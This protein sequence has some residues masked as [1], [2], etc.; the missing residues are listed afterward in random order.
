MEK[1]NEELSNIFKF[2]KDG[3]FA[4]KD[5]HKQVEPEASI[6]RGLEESPSQTPNEVGLQ[7]LELTRDEF[8][9]YQEIFNRDQNVAISPTPRDSQKQISENG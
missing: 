3:I 1:L 5:I 8:Y 9:I 6:K 2:S 4:V 7:M